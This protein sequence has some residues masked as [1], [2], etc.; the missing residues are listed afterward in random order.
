[1]FTLF[2]IKHSM[3][4]FIKVMKQL[5]FFIASRTYKAHPKE[6]VTHSKQIQ[7]TQ[8]MAFLKTV[9]T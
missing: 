1:M 3:G 9:T 2:V 7:K 5:H 8:C 6:I 4:D